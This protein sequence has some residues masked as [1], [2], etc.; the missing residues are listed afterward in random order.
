MWL[1][2]R[3]RYATLGGRVSAAAKAGI[4]S[5]DSMNTTA[6][7]DCDTRK[8]SISNYA[9]LTVRRTRWTHRE[10]R[11]DMAV[12][13]PSAWIVGLESE[14]K[15]AAFRKMSRVTL[16]GVLDIERHTCL[17]GFGDGCVDGEGRVGHAA[18]NPKVVT[19][20]MDRVGH[21]IECSSSNLEGSGVRSGRAGRHA[22]AHVDSLEGQYQSRCLW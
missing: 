22:E 5:C 14:C 2:E 6:M 15:P 8:A 12:H 4:S 1:L 11:V 21:G 3:D 10:M 17:L 7:P 13:Q 20:E 16:D 19:V 18:E 9:A